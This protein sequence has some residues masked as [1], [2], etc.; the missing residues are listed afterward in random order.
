M[1]KF[2][3]EAPAPEPVVTTKLNLSPE[4]LFAFLQKQDP[5][6]MDD[7]IAK[8][9]HRTVKDDIRLADGQAMDG[10]REGG[11]ALQA[12]QNTVPNSLLSWYGQ[13]SF[14]GN[15]LAGI[16]AQHWLIYKCC[17]LPAR[18]AIRNGYEITVNDGTEVDTK[19]LDAMRKADRRYQINRVM[20]EFITKGRIFGIRIAMFKIEFEN[21]ELE[22]EFYEK[23][24]NIDGVVPGS[25]KGIVQ[26]DPYWITPELD[27]EAGSD[28]TSKFFYQPTWWR[29]NAQRI[30]RTHLIV[31]LNGFLMDTLRPTYLYGGVSVPQRI[32]ERVYCAER[33]ANEAPQL[34]MTKR[35]MIQHVDLAQAITNPLE[36]KARAELAALLQTNYSTKFVGE[37]E[38]VEHFDTTLA[39]LDNV[40]MTQYQIVAAAANVP[41][42]KLLGTTPK[43][44]NSTGEHEETSYHEELESIQNSDLTDLLERHHML[45]IRSEI[46]P[47]FGIEPFETSVNWNTLNSVNADEIAA[48]NKLKAETDQVL[49]VCGA[50]DANDVRKRIITDPDSGFN[51]ILDEEIEVATGLGDPEE[52]P[53]ADKDFDPKLEENVQHD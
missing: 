23:P 34:A 37:E 48:I 17:N 36:F 46:A 15:Q 29:V 53:D 41:A 16:L 31:F 52:D 40:I 13:Q 27:L 9:I 10:I 26:I 21:P 7:L 39:D 3:K 32:Y 47:K 25:Y 38:V 4:T 1:F 51:G 24:F 20:E 6:T 5:V 35:T 49:I 18:D 22:L 2:F 43:G 14:I 42:T 11:F 8:H 12:A 28:P 50:I 30:H 33:T 44:F 19:I 45:L